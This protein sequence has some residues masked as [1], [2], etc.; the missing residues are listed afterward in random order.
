MRPNVYRGLEWSLQLDK[1]K[2]KEG[3]EY[4]FVSTCEYVKERNLK[5]YSIN[6]EKK[7]NKSAIGNVYIACESKCQ[8]EFIK[9]SYKAS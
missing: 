9:R 8:K 3:Q 2:K 1:D 7:T 6:K 4:A 5:Y